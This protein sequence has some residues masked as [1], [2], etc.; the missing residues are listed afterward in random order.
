MASKTRFKMQEFNFKPPA[1]SVYVTF[2]EDPEFK[3]TQS[4]IHAKQDLNPR[5]SVMAT[6][7]VVGEGIEDIQSG[8]TILFNRS[9]AIMVK[10]GIYS[11]KEEFIEAEV[12]CIL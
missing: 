11:I 3:E 10:E 5:R 4:G 7:S 6:V 9:R 2:T 1:G 12:P 8:M